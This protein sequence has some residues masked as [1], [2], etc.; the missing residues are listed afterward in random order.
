MERLLRQPNH[1][2]FKR[3]LVQWV[4]L[5]H[6]CLGVKEQL[7]KASLAIGSLS[8]LASYVSRSNMG[9]Y[10]ASRDWGMSYELL[11]FGRL[12]GLVLISLSLVWLLGAL[13]WS[14][15]RPPSV[16]SR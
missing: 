3:P 10:A 9:T 13:L 1:D 4:L 12:L 15:L 2:A 8:L 14:R 6:H 16:G 7:P 11:R 5:F